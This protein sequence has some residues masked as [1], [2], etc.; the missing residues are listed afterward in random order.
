MEGYN[1]TGDY[2]I[3]DNYIGMLQLE[4]TFYIN[5]NADREEYIHNFLN[6]LTELL[7]ELIFYISINS[8]WKS[9]LNKLEYNLLVVDLDNEIALFSYF[10]KAVTGKVN[11][12]YLYNITNNYVN[13]ILKL[14]SFNLLL[15]VVTYKRDNEKLII[16]EHF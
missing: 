4:I 6:Y 10:V 5:S 14:F 7:P 8:Q 15:L 3:M 2:V 13:N 1:E 12:I 11:G 9:V 16:R